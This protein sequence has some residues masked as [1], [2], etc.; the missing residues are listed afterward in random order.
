MEKLK[1]FTRAEG[2]HVSDFDKIR[3]AAFTLAEVLITLGI[4]GVVAA[5]TMPALI[6][7]YRAKVLEIS[8]KK[9]DS[10]ITQAM[11]TTMYEYGFTRYYDFGIFCSG[12]YCKDTKPEVYLPLNNLWKKQFSGLEETGWQ[13]IKSKNYPFAKFWGEKANFNYVFMVA[14]AKN[15]TSLKA[16][17]MKDGMLISEI[18]FEANNASELGDKSHRYTIFPFI[19]VD[20]NGPAKGPNRL[21]YDMFYWVKMTCYFTYCDPLSDNVRGCYLWARK[22][23]NPYDNSVSYWKSLYKSKSYWE[24]LK[25]IGGGNGEPKELY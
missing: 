15:N 24:K 25:S 18:I 19:F 23:Q 16:Y 7:N 10:I 17:F 2:A 14:G 12:E 22:D 1:G 13:Q 11:Q 20:T 8:F 3:R 9:A 6:N 21:G 5:M 4:V